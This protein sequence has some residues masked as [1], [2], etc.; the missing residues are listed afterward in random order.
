[1]G[2]LFNSSRETLDKI[3][4]MVESNTPGGYFRFGDGDVALA[5]GVTELLQQ[6]NPT[7]RRY[8]KDA[9][10]LKDDRILRTLPLHT[11]E[12]DTLEDGMFPGNHE[13][14]LDWCEELY[15]KFQDIVS[16]E[17]ITLYTNVALAH[18]AVQDPNSAADFLKKIRPK[19]KYFIG[20][21]ETPR[22]LLNILFDE[23]VKF[24]KTP[25]SNS[26]S[27]FESIYKEFTEQVGDDDEFSVVVTS[28]G[29]SG[30]AMQKRIW[31]NYKNF[32]LFDFGSVMDAFCGTNTRVWMEL[33]KF[34][35]DAF[36]EL[37]K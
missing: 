18:I 27:K 17:D 5:T 21:E 22:S 37:L 8:M 15:G 13:S 3:S 33:T 31:D 29:C 9:M 6:S 14:P 36:L 4:E 26:F 12:W 10:R 24:I 7:L 35:S 11:K 32:F 25:A 23:H 20:N 28:M 30:R 2:V 16:E 19:V 1:M 34:D